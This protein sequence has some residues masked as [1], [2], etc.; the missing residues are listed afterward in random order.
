MPLLRLLRKNREQEAVQLQERIRL[1]ADKGR[2][3]AIYDQRLGLLARWYFELRILE[4]CRRCTR[5]GYSM[6]LLTLGAAVTEPKSTTNRWSSAESDS[7]RTMMQQVRE[8]DLVGALG[9]TEFAIGLIQCDRQG[10][11]TLLRRLVPEVEGIDWQ[12]GLAVF[13]DDQLE[14]KD[15]LELALSRRAPWKVASNDSRQAA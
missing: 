3:L 5:Y 14:G 12:V 4:E 11:A 13:P 8:T 1:E 10:A 15:L 6:V 2:Q 9:P 7:I